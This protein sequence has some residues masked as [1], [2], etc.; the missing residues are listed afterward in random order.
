MNKLSIPRDNSAKA[1]PLDDIF[2]IVN[3]T[4]N[5]NLFHLIFSIGLISKGIAS[6]FCCIDFSFRL[7]KASYL[8]WATSTQCLCFTASVGAASRHF[9]WKNIIQD[10][11]EK[12]E[13]GCFDTGACQVLTVFSES[14]GETFSLWKRLTELT[15]SSAQP[16]DLAYWADDVSVS[17]LMMWLCDF[18]SC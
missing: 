15:V 17:D 8:W 1:V 12:A 7:L 3:V 18:P 13:L 9:R 5:P 4:I 11:V 16:F 6:V 2:P 10:S 14:Y